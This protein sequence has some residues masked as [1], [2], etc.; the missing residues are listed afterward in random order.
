MRAGQV[1]LA[2]Y[3]AGM[4]LLEIDP[5]VV[6]PGWT[7]LLIIVALGIVMVFLFF[8]MRRQFRNINL[9]DG[10]TGTEPSGPPADSVGSPAGEQAHRAAQNA[11][12]ADG[13]DPPAGASR[14]SAPQPPS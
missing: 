11:P 10:R 9:P 7:P 13:G 12:V 4:T 8:S 5:N 6:K 2:E 3:S 1:E 14:S